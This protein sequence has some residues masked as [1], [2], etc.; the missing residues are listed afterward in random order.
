[1][2]HTMWEKQDYRRQGKPAKQVNSAGNQGSGGVEQR[3]G[4]NCVPPDWRTGRD[5]PVR[6]VRKTTRFHGSYVS[7]P[8]RANLLAIPKCPGYHAGSGFPFPC[9]GGPRMYSVVLLVALNG[10]V[11]TPA[12]G[13]RGGCH[14]C[15]GGC[16]GGGCYGGG[17]GGRYG[18][19]YSCCGCY[20]GY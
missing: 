14:G 7:F 16:Y 3:D 13:H 4:G 18:G 1:E 10:A 5:L 2:R 17:Y 11:E 12:F 19:G 15:R 6:I 20:G 8:F 9:K